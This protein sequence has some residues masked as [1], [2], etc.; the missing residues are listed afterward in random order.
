[1]NSIGYEG[2]VINND[3]MPIEFGKTKNGM[4]LLKVSIAEQH[5][6]KNGKV[7]KEFQDPNK[8][9]EDW[10][11][12]TTSWHKL[13][14]FGDKAEALAADPDFNHGSIVV[15][16]GASYVEEAPFKTR[17]DVL[18]AGRPESIG[19]NAGSVEVKSYNGKVF[20]PSDNAPGIIWDGESAIPELK[21]GSG[22]DRPR[23]FE[24]D[25]TEGF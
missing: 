11:P 22:G 24:V 3:R 23:T 14:V 8:T 16:E 6:G 17:D 12:T 18:R 20:G 19:D 25:E 15:V 10:V 21:G 5:R 7:A 2:R 1:M 4:V 13:T 9:A